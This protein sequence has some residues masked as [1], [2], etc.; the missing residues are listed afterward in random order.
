MRQLR[1]I[2]TYS[3]CSGRPKNSAIL[4]RCTQQHDTCNSRQSFVLTD[5]MSAS[6]KN[7]CLDSRRRNRLHCLKSLT[8]CHQ[9]SYV[10]STHVCGHALWCAVKRDLVAHHI[11]YLLTSDGSRFCVMTLTS[12]LMT[13]NVNRLLRD[14]TMLQNRQHP[15]ILARNCPAASQYLRTSH[16][17]AVILL[18]L[19]LRL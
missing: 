13:F 17:T 18:H 11:T 7:Y 16:V 4:N 9:H 19:L 3:C 15:K 5:F 14:Q 2:A 12:D 1:Y 8:N 6:N 10:S